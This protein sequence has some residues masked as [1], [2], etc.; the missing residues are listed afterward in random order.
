[1]TS[2][3]SPP[4]HPA[5]QQKF[6]SKEREQIAM[7]QTAFAQLGETRSHVSVSIVLTLMLEG[8]S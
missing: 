4:I 7:M 5:Q 1:M 2:V 3:A 8:S 6:W